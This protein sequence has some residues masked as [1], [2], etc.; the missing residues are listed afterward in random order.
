MEPNP[1]QT[2]QKTVHAIQHKTKK[3]EYKVKQNKKDSYTTIRTKNRASALAQ[4]DYKL[5]NAIPR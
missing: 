4:I 3:R 5:Y 2:D 1:E